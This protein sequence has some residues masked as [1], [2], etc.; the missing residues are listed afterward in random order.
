M[1]PLF[2]F[3]LAWVFTSAMTFGQ[4]PSETTADEEKAV[5]KMQQAVQVA[6]QMGPLPANFRLCLSADLLSP[7]D[8][9][10]S[11]A[12]QEKW[13][14]TSTRIRRYLPRTPA[15]GRQTYQLVETR[16]YDGKKLAKILVEGKAFEF[17]DLEGTGPSLNFAGT[18]YRLGH[19]SIEIHAGKQIVVCI[20]EACVAAGYR[21]SKAELLSDLYTRLALLARQTFENR[22]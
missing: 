12:F 6:S 15:G 10:R 9:S 18:G 13:E 22:N 19:R 8:P 11:D 1:K 20:E 14:F 7:T 4:S 16:P 17:E 21:K 5:A 2:H 3:C